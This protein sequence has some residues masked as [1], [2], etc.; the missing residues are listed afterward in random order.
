ML[1]L[2][3]NAR[4]LGE[5]KADDRGLARNHVISWRWGVGSVTTNTRTIHTN[6]SVY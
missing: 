5:R 4:G 3:H 2:L 6:E 1:Y